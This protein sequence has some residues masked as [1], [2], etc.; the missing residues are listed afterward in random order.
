M[1]TQLIKTRL[2]ELSV[3]EAGEGVPLLAVHGALTS[4][5]SFAHLLEAPPRRC[6]VVAVDLPGHGRSPAPPS[7]HKGWAGLS[8]CLIALTEALALDEVHL[9]GHSMGGGISAY[10][11][12]THPERIRS[13]ILIDSVTLPFSLPLKGR[14]PLIPVV[15]ELVFL[16][17]YGEPMF[18]RFF[19][20]DIF[21]DEGKIDRERMSAYYREFDGNRRT[22]LTAVRMSA[23]P[24]PVAR[25]LS[26]ITCPTLVLWGRNDPLIPLFVG[27]QTAAQ[28]PGAALSI[29]ERCGHSPLEEA[30][31]PALRAIIDFWEN[32]SLNGRA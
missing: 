31:K 2:G 12:A 32:V 4:A 11:A 23:E 15:G 7:P 29:I 21:F 8:E 18:R 19:R 25:A 24:G 20:D 5:R 9:L 28:I 16:H 3:T 10:T 14:I 17:L 1:K 26:A 27:E 30:P 6:R 22:A 13:L